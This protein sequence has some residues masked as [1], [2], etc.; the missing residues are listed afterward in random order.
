MKE[1]KISSDKLRQILNNVNNMIFAT[2]GVEYILVT[3]IIIN[4]Y[5]A[6]NEFYGRLV[7]CEKFLKN[8]DLDK[9]RRDWIILR[10]QIE[11]FDKI[12]INNNDVNYYTTEEV[13]KLFAKLQNDMAKRV[14]SNCGV[15]QDDA[16]YISPIIPLD[17]FKENMK[18]NVQEES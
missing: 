17:W 9:A 4:N 11:G 14:L 12:I 13:E 10:K 5:N 1:F 6:N 8:V 3:N 18:K 16:A 7:D 2:S 15:S